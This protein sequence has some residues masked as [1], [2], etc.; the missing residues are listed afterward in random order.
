MND[1]NLSG[2]KVEKKAR[3]RAMKVLSKLISKM[4]VAEVQKLNIKFEKK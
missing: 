3:V 4:T 1:K 2:P